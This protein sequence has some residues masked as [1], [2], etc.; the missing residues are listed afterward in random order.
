MAGLAG[1]GSRGCGT[2][3]AA[4]GTGAFSASLPTSS[5]TFSSSPASSVPRL[6]T[7]GFS[8]ALLQELDALRALQPALK[9]G[10]LLEH[11]VPQAGAMARLPCHRGLLPGGSKAL[12]SFRRPAL[13]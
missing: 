3:R 11:D 5:D 1:M 6:S 7:D 12:P 13:L 8:Q 4:Q 10:N 9:I 2:G